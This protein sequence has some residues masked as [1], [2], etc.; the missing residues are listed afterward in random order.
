MY[1]IYEFETNE[2]VYDGFNTYEEALAEF[3]KLGLSAEKYGI[4]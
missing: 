1:L 3:N 4:R 2:I